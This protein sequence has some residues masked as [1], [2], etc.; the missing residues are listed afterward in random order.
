MP[1]YRFFRNFHLN[2]MFPVFLG[3]IIFLYIVIAYFGE[4]NMTRKHVEKFNKQQALQT[5]VAANGIQQ[6]YNQISGVNDALIKHVKTIVEIEPKPE[7]ALVNF[8]RGIVDSHQEI[9]GIALY[10]NDNQHPIRW[11][12]DNQLARNI[13]EEWRDQFGRGITREKMKFVPPLCIRSTCST[14]AL[15]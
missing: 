8:I 10:F 12:D 2:V 1:K 6:N 3:T 9:M 5:L 7:K 15:S 4:R 14:T 11:F 13:S